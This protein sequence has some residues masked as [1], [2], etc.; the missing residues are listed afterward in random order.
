M[1]RSNAI[2]CIV[3]ALIVGAFV[4][5]VLADT[6]QP[7][8]TEITMQSSGGTIGRCVLTNEGQIACVPIVRVSEGYLP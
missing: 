4:G 8:Y 5:I 1:S 2:G 7:V 3:L 6:F